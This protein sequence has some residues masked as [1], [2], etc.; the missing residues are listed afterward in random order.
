MN[1]KLSSLKFIVNENSEYVAKIKDY[2]N[3]G[4]D[5]SS[6]CGLKNINVISSLECIVSIIDD[7]LVVSQETNQSLKRLII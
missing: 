1:D 3:N 2:R 4:I 7:I 5:E 6:D